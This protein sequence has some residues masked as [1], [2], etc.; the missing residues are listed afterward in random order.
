[1]EFNEQAKAGVR[2]IDVSAQDQNRYSLSDEDVI[3]LAR[4][5]VIIEKHYQR[6]MD[7]EW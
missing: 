4:Y 1:M 5:A 6:P 7:I 2:T 3:A